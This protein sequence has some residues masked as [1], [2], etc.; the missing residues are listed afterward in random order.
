[1]VRETGAAERVA[2]LCLFSLRE[3]LV[4]VVLKRGPES[5]AADCEDGGEALTGEHA[6]QVLSR[7]NM[8]VP[9]RRRSQAMRKAGSRA[10][11]TPDA[12]GE[13][14]RSE[15]LSMHLDSTYL[16]SLYLAAQE[17]REGP[18]GPADRDGSQTTGCCCG[19]MAVVVS[20]SEKA[21]LDSVRCGSGRRTRVNR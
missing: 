6:G 8:F 13:P 19:T 16:M 18:S 4:A 7:E 17:M 1:V 12:Q 3:H 14:A 11:Q 9:G 2:L 21:E 5:C 20:D 15:T 10:P